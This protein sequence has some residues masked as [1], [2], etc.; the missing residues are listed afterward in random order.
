MKHKIINRVISLVIAVATLIG[1]VPMTSITVWAD[2]LK[3]DDSKEYTIDEKP[4]TPSETVE[5]EMAA[6]NPITKDRSEGNDAKYAVYV[7]GKLHDKGEFS[8]M[9]K[10]AMELAPYAVEDAD[11]SN[12]DK[13]KLV[14]F[15]LYTDIEYNGKTFSEKTMTVS[16]KKITIDLNGHVLKR[17]DGGSVIKVTDNAVL[18]IMDSD[19]TKVNKGT[20]DS[21]DKWSYDAEKG[22]TPISGG[23]ITGGNCGTGD[24]GGLYIDGKSTVY[25]QGGTIAGN[26]ADV[27]SGVY[28]EDNSTLDMSHGVSQIC[29]NYSAGTTSDGG[30]IFLRSDCAV[31]GGYVHHNLADDYGG[32]IRA[33]GNNI[34]IKNVVIYANK[35]EEYGGG[36]YIERSST[37]QTVTVTG[38]KII[39]NYA[40]EDGGGAYIYDLKMVYMSDCWVENNTADDEGGGICVSDWTGTDLTISG[41]MIV[42]NN[43]ESK[44]K[45]QIKSN[46]YLEGDDDLIVGTLSI[47]SEIWIRTEESASDY[48]GADHPILAAETSSSHL[49]FFADEDGFCVMYQGDPNQDNYRN[50][51]LYKGI[52]TE[53]DVKVLEDYA[54]KLLA[55]KNYSVSTGEYAGMET[56]LYK[57]YFEYI[58]MST[59]EFYSASPFY[60]SDGYFLEDPTVYNTHLATMSVNLA[61]AAFGR[62]TADVGN[63]AYANHFANIKQLYADIG[64]ADVNFFANEDYQ[65]KPTYYGD[66]DRLSTIA[67]AISQKEIS[68]NDDSY[69][70]V[71]IA[72]RGGNYEAEWASNVTIGSSGEAAGFAD[73]ANQVFAHVENYIKN[74]GLSEKVKEGKVKFWVVGYSRAGATANLTSKRLVDAFANVGNDIYGYTFE[75]PMG[76]VES[77]K[78]KTDYTGNGTYPTIHN[79]VN[80]LDFVTLVAPSEMGFMRYGVDHVI[81]ATD[82]G[83]GFDSAY[84]EQREKMLIQLSAINPYYYFSDHWKV[85]ELSLIYGG[86]L[87]GN[88][89]IDD[90][91]QL[92]DDPNEECL[93]MYDFLRWF[94]LKVQEYGL[95]ISSIDQSREHYSD[96]KPLGSIEGNNK[97]DLP[98]SDP[99]Y[100]FGYSDMSVGQ[101]AAELV[102]MLMGSLT[103]EQFSALIE[104]VTGSALGFAMTTGV[105]VGP[106]LLAALIASP[107]TALISTGVTAKVVYDLLLTDWDTHSEEFKAE[108][109]N[110]IMHLILNGKNPVWDILTEEQAKAVAEG[111]PVVLWFALNFA[112]MDNNTSEGDDGMWGIPTFI[113]N[114][115][116]IA[117]NHYQEV[118]VAWVRSY[119]DYYVGDTQAY[120]IDTDK[121][122]NKAPTGTYARG[123]KTITLSARDGSAIFY[124]VDGGET[125]SLYTK[126]VALENAP[127][128]LLTFSIY[129]GVKSEVAEISLNGWSGSLLGNGNIWFLLIGSAFIV[130]FCVVCL[131]MGRKKKKEA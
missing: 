107:L 63:N 94:F 87:F 84:Y 79:T 20:L 30:A 125:W 126:T 110:T 92:W 28:L 45:G 51:Y 91:L 53:K 81:G 108:M 38:C 60:Y 12:G 5:K 96:F 65:I 98:Y 72:I 68:V 82:K 128:H 104:A 7:D 57:G 85:A 62:Y 34:L 116:V 13:K 56:P 100:N 41:K 16:N 127:E 6:R 112:S 130:G 22:K 36:L 3:K 95:N 26:K 77:A 64:C 15:V 21:K 18:T 93:S 66:K 83:E 71:P 115:N 111:L 29:Y 10:L 73:A 23:V 103:D 39:G 61:V 131:E 44:S 89:V 50:F 122:E 47:G 124:S 4:L 8:E 88:G 99:E 59:T 40:G 106:L 90:E 86:L 118:T 120:R 54:T 46:L 31:I 113:T 35:A 75:A 17:T 37:G 69:T 1:V 2:G 129:R 33:K 114:M 70:L 78:N 9:W 24:G 48:N 49:F 109:I 55:N 121:V 74:Y 32:G 76:G 101:A 80:E 97:T 11:H 105:T 67:V 25:L 27:G 42:R 43:Y 52:R 58:L 123:T 117:S 19:P 14:E 102:S 119:D